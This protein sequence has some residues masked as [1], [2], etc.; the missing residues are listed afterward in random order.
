MMIPTLDL[1]RERQSVLARHDHIEQNDID[2][3]GSKL[4]A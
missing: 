1:A 4:S 3:L 2:R